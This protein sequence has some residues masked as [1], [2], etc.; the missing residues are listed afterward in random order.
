[1]SNSPPESPTIQPVKVLTPWEDFPDNTYE[2]DQGLFEPLQLPKIMA[3]SCYMFECHSNH[4][5]DFCHIRAEMTK[6]KLER[7]AV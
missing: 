3:S 6:R 5:L 1:M 2:Q 7:L 4:G